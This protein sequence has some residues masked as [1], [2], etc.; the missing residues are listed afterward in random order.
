M[1]HRILLNVAFSRLT[2]KCI[3]KVYK[4]MPRSC[5]SYGYLNAGFSAEVKKNCKGETVIVGKP[6]IV[7]GGINS[8]LVCIV[9]ILIKLKE[10]IS[11][12]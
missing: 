4:I 9:D 1:E 2:T 3:V 5:N 8:A 10:I 6:T 12:F 7:Y 11:K